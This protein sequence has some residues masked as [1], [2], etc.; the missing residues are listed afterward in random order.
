MQIT[1]SSLATG[2]GPSGV[3]HRRCL[4]RHDHA[5]PPHRHDC[6]PRWCISRRVLAPRGTPIPVGQT[7]YV[8][9][10]AGRCQRRGGPV[11]VIRPGDRVF[12]EPGE[13]S[14]ARC[15]ARPVHDPRGDARSRR[16]RHQRTWGEH[17]SDEEY[18]P[19]SRRRTQHQG[20]PMPGGRHERSCCRH[21][22]RIDRSG[23][24][25]AGQ[26]RQARRAGRPAPE[27]ADA[28]AEV[29][30]NAGFEVSTAPS[31]CPA[32]ESVHALVETA[33]AL[34]DITGVI[35]AAGVSPSQASPAT[36]LQ[37]DL[38]GTALR[39]RGVRQRHR[40][41]RRRASSSRRSPG[42]V[43]GAFDRRTE[44]RPGDHAG[45]GAARAA[46]ASSP[47]R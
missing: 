39:A 16:A 47:T 34:G 3:V 15:G 22:S 1:R 19:P 21:R 26:R 32:R 6:R 38:Y 8:L 46:D 31:T 7:I 14:L 28:A 4:R 41:R 5:T 44:R 9:E 17:V 12:F 25:P 20:T 36:I 45:R 43:S 30:R 40:A 2:T 24:R 27:N 37:V 13:R 35:H 33:T 23:H 42:I 11:E 29:L 18:T 10:G